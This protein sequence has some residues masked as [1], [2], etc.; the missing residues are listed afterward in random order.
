MGCPGGERGL[1]CPGVDWWGGCVAGSVGFVGR[2]RELSRLRAALGG[3][4]RLLLV[5]GDAGVGKTRFAGEGLRLAAASGTV[6]VWGACLPLAE[7]LPL[8]PVAQALGELSRVGCGRLLEAALGVAR[9]YVRAEVARLVPGLG[10]GG[11]EEGGQGGGWQRERLFSAVA[12]LLAAVAGRS[13]VGLVVEDVHWADSATLDCLTFLLRAQREVPLTV[14]VTCRSDEVPL[15]AQVA[16]WL[17][18]VRGS[19]VVEEI[20]LGPL[21]RD[22]V[23]EQV[24]ALVGGAVPRGLA[25]EVYARGEGN[26]FFTEQLVAAARAGAADGVGEMSSGLPDRL[27]AL[28]VARAERRS[29]QAREVL[30]ALAVAGRPLSEAALGDVTGLG[31][32]AVRG[33]LRELAAAKLLADSTAEGA[34]RPRHALLAEAVAGALLPSERVVLHERTAQM[35]EAAGDDSLAAEAAGH[36][37]AAGRAAGELPARVAAAGAAERVFGYAEAAAH[38]QRAI[39]LVQALPGA[40][41]TAGTDLPGLYR[42]AI[43]AAVLSGDTQRAGRLAEEAYRRFAGH[44]DH[45][46][47]AVIC[48]R[49]GYLRGIHTPEAGFPLMQRALELFELGPPSAE[50]AEA[51]VQYAATTLSTY[52]HWEDGCAALDQALEIA[53]AASATAVIPLVLAKL[54]GLTF[55]RGKIQEGFATL[56]RARAAAETAGDSAAL[57]ELAVHESWYLLVMGNFASAEEVALRG[58]RAARRAGLDSWFRTTYLVANA[59]EAM[60][61]RGHT[62]D[63]GALVDPLT[64]GP[65]GRDDWF[66]T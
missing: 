34:H 45:A 58:L 5:V 10:S 62:A 65:P 15:D 23:G 31:A 26:P 32:E 41:D 64:T 55:S 36:W 17:A 56:H 57:L 37:A 60:W 1:T 14:V 59:A 28:L 6:S 46:T 11:P 20:R 16:A 30:A 13:V 50:H 35:L 29:G 21:T 25:D 39:E 63:A 22:E 2:Q 12:E 3:D 40:A 51:L 33:G 4:S 61:S 19:A 47:A 42:R 49:A 52:R 44:P 27:A 53:G 9:P 38:W 43:D 24:A 8:L 48:Q 66:C 18:Q 54:A 7:K